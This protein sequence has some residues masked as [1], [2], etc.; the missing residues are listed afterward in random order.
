MIA[1]IEASTQGVDRRFVVTNLPSRAKTLYERVY[2]AR[3][4]AEN[5]IKAHKLHLVSD[6]TSCH[7]AKLIIHDVPRLKRMVQELIGE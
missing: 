6:R 1:R 5:L 7:S 4:Q 3:G 2:C